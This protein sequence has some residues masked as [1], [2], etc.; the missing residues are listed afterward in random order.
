M[1]TKTIA[2]ACIV[3]VVAILAIA[4][5]VVL[6]DSPTHDVRVNQPSSQPGPAVPQT[7]GAR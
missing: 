1:T 5:G 7:G 4:V 6:Q 3:A 2:A